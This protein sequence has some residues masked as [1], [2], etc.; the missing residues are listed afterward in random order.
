MSSLFVHRCGAKSR[1]ISWATMGLALVL[2]AGCD[3]SGQ[4]ALVP[5]SADAPSTA[6]TTP[7]TKLVERDVEAP[8]VF[9]VT[10]EGLWDGRPSLGGVWVAHPDVAEPERVIIRNEGN[11]QFVIG[12]LFRKERELPGPKLQ[13]S[14]DAASSLGILAGAP[15]KLNVTALRREE[16]EELVETEVAQADTPEAIETPGGA[17]TTTVDPI[18]VASAAIEA[19]PATAPTAAEGQSA[20]VPDNPQ[21]ETAET[22]EAAPPDKPFVQIGIFSRERSARRAARQMT[23]AGVIPTVKESEINGQPFWRVVV[24]PAASQT[25]IA[26]LTEQIKA[27]GFTDAYTVVD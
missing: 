20:E 1:P 17:E 4:F 7:S 15:A 12:A 5:P 26:S 13:I 9:S 10:D 16:S 14:S 8:E 22:A 6:G 21:V 27:Q 18:A 23:R 25:E 2:L 3:E 19:V 24:G 11:G